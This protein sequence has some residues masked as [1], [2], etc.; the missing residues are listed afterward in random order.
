[1]IQRKYSIGLIL[2]YPATLKARGQCT[3]LQCAS[4]PWVLSTPSNWEPLQLCRLL[5]FADELIFSTSGFA[6][7]FVPLVP[8]T[9]TMP[10]ALRVGG[11][12]VGGL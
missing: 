4:M 9:G 10:G 8:V 1:M 6:G 12:F 11:S 3:P 5:G 7:Y 2:Y